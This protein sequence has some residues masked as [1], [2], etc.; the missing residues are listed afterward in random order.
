MTLS[1]EFQQWLLRHQHFH[2]YF[3]PTSSW[4]SLVERWF[5]K[6]TNCKLRRSAHR[7]VTEL[8]DFIR[9]WIIE[10]KGNPQAVHL[11]QVRGRNP[12][13]RSEYCQRIIDSGH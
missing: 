4:L 2:L 7:S 12:Q 9:K 11:D 6:L 1:A 10:W 3:T 13:D 8:E 5:A